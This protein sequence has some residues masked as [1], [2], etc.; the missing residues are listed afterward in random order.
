MKA[1][2]VQTLKTLRSPWT[3]RAFISL[4][5]VIMTKVLKMRVKWRVGGSKSFASRPDLMPKMPAPES[6]FIVLRLTCIEKSE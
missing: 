1:K 6:S 3:L 4:K 2:T 5:R